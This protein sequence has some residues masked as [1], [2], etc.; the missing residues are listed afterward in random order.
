MN[1]GW[2]A[3]Y[4]QD[5]GS[6]YGRVRDQVIIIQHQH[7]GHLCQGQVIKQG[8][9]G[10][11]MAHGRGVANYRFPGLHHH[12]PRRCDGSSSLDGVQLCTRLWIAFVLQRFFSHQ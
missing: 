11:F 8:G 5:H 10:Q 6:V 12:S 7:Q 1:T 4:E 3:V 9:E 2:Q